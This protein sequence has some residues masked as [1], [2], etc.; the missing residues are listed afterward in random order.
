MR[1]AATP[2]ELRDSVRPLPEHRRESVLGFLVEVVA[3]CPGCDRPVRRV[4]PRALVHGQ[5]VHLECGAAAVPDPETVADLRAT[6]AD[7][8]SPQSRALLE[9]RLAE[10]EGAT[11]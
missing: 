3:E 6:L 7:T 8:T 1:H 9:R 5:L 10:L 11:R 2:G 4:D